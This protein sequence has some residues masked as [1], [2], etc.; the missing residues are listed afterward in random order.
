M[1]S[2][3]TIPRQILSFGLALDIKFIA[4]GSSPGV[5]SGIPVEIRVRPEFLFTE[6]SGKQLGKIRTGMLIMVNQ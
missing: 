1:S 5:H 4:K 3:K 6:S 2:N